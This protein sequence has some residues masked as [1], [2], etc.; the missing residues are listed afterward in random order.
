MS[1]AL[2]PEVRA[3]IE[4]GHLATLVT[5]N[6]DGSPQA[7]VV[8]VGMDGDE[9]VTAHLGRYQKVRNI[10]RDPRVVLTIITGVSGEHG[11]DQYLVVHGTAR[12]TEGG[13]VPLLDRLAGVYL[14]PD[15]SMPLPDDPPAGVV[16]RITIDRVTGVGPWAS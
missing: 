13:A 5:L 7:S 6:P 14:G 4:G 3:A 8:W 11:L 16:N 9:V 12:I 2:T 1:D 15:Q 10:E